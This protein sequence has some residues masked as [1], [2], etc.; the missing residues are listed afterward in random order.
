MLCSDLSSFPRDFL[1]SPCSGVLRRSCLFFFFFE[2]FLSAFEISFLSR[3]LLFCGGRSGLGRLSSVLRWVLWTLLLALGIFVLVFA[4]A[5]SCS[6]SFSLLAA[7]AVPWE[8][9]HCE[10]V[11]GGPQVVLIRGISPGAAASC[12]FHAGAC[13]LLGEIFY[14]TSF[15]PLV[16]SFFTASSRKLAAIGVLCVVFLLVVA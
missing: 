10:E 8:F 15:T 16:V 7:R 14:S 5:V 3:P 11:S 12:L 4:W 6:V 13:G 9:L 1:L 2:V